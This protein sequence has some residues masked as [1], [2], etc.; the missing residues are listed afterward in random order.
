MYRPREPEQEKPHQPATP[1]RRAEI[2]GGSLLNAR[3]SS[4]LR[5]TN[6]SHEHGTSGGDPRPQENAITHDAITHDAASDEH[7]RHWPAGGEPGSLLDAARATAPAQPPNSGHTTVSSFLPGLGAIGALGVD[8]FITWLRQ[9]WL[10]ILA[11]VA[12]CTAAALVYAMTATPRYIVYTDIII[13]PANINIV[14]DD[15]FTANPMRDAQMAEVESKMRVLISRNVL[16]R[17]IDNLRLTEDPEFVA[18][19]P[20]AGLKSLLGLGGADDDDQ[21][22]GAMRALSERVDAHREDRSFVVVL[23]VWSEDPEKAVILS[24]AI[25]AAFEEELFR[26]ASDSV[27]RV[28]QSLTERLDELRRNVTEA[29][30]R[31]EEF[32]RANGL[33]SSN[34]ELVSNQLSVELNTQ[35][36]EAQQRLIQAQ[37]RLTQ[38]N[39]AIEQGRVA[40]TSEFDSDTMAGLRLQYNTLQQQMGSIELT[41]GPRHP[42][43]VSALSER[44]S[45]DAAMTREARRI[46]DVARAELAR[47]QAAYDALRS[48]AEEERSNVFTDNAALIELRDLEREARSRAAIYETYLARAQ[49]ITE[50]EKID[51]TNVRIIS[52]PVP[53]EA[54]NW[55]PRTMLLLIAAG[56]LGLAL[57]IAVA[58]SLG[59]WR[60]LR[61]PQDR[62]ISA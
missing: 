8:D 37:S 20:L 56:I 11:I 7:G 59:L 12:M 1:G 25:V 50:R 35:V 9:G 57:G 6:I 58:L 52:Q 54:R 43:M 39:N 47:E 32:R 33:Q 41:Y 44:R 45:L 30:Q 55:P 13:D 36:L 26:S 2:R 61:T 42:R 4:K 5:S 19:D 40:A 23:R 18:P 60:F 27:S 15:V 17:V 10:W 38:M 31:V 46:L 16:A 53:P 34:G 28:A 49:Q 24:Q 14:S 51:T 29:E 62:M 48:K 21:Q 3:A 22:L